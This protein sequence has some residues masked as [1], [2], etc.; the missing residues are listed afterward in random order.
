M[1]MD[2][3]GP[4]AIRARIQELRARMGQTDQR[5]FED[6]LGAPSAPNQVKPSGLTG[7]ISSGGSAP[8]EILDGFKP[9]SGDLEINPSAPS[10]I[11]SLIKKVAREQGVDEVLFEALVGKESG[12]DPMARSKVGAM[13]LTQLMPGTAAELGV[14][15]PFDPEQNLRGG[16]KYLAQQI[17]KF[18]DAR[19]ALAAYNAGPGA[20][21]KAGNQVPNYKETKKYVDDI[22]RVVEARSR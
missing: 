15:N 1:N 22:M 16:A 14:T 4:N 17:M 12:F 2:L 7:V 13:G 6:Y 10:E 21:I 11:R 8:Q 3:L 5:S 19:L 18:G 20:V 9:L